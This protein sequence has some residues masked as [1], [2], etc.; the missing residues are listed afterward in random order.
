MQYFDGEER[1]GCFT[2]SSCC[3]VLFIVPCL[4]PTLP[5]VG[6][7]CVIVVF[8]DLTQLLFSIVLTV[9]LSSDFTVLTVNFSS[10]STLLTV[11]FSLDFTF[12]TD[13]FYSDSTVRTINLNSDSTVLT[14]RLTS[15]LVSILARIIRYL[16]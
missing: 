14:V 9:N 15:D 11:N 7:K 1:A 16:L 5:S 6:Q 10:D 13:N 4:F 2:L 12:L 3:L 8:P